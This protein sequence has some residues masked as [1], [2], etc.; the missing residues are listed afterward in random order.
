MVVGIGDGL[1]AHGLAHM[2]VVGQAQHRNPLETFVLEDL[3]NLGAHEDQSLHE[4]GGDRA[5]LGRLQCP[6]QVVQHVH[7]L[8]EDGVVPLL[9]LAFDGAGAA[10]SIA[11]VVR[12]QGA[13]GAEDF[14]EA[15]FR[16]AG[17]AMVLFGGA[18]FGRQLIGFV[19]LGLGLGLRLGL[20]GGVLHRNHSSFFAVGF[21]GPVVCQRFLPLGTT[22]VPGSQGI[23][24]L[25]GR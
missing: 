23:I 12:L 11:L 19:G 24:A 20:G 17:T 2:G 3:E 18:G 5:R 16:E 7:E 8:Q 13:V 1:D 10:L 4:G 15:I 6:I 9:E 14:G 25:G 22:D 21:L